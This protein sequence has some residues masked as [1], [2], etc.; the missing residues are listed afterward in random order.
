MYLNEHNKMKRLIFTYLLIINAILCYSQNWD[1]L[2]N[3][4]GELNEFTFE[5]D[6]SKDSLNLWEY[7]YTD[8][9][10]NKDGKFGVLLLQRKN[11]VKDSIE[12]DSLLPKILLSIYPLSHFDT[13]SQFEKKRVMMLS[14]CYPKCGAT[15]VKNKN[16]VLWSNPFSIKCAFN[17]SGID[18]TRWNAKNILKQ[19]TEKEYGSIMELLKDLPIENNE[20]IEWINN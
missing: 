15:I 5:F 20:N 16:F 6:V 18:Y 11:Y 9:K 19:V 3:F 14:C 17:C 13:I 8:S 2:I 10:D 1:S 4:N 7:N 12:N